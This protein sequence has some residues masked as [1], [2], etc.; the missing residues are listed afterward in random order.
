MSAGEI[1]AAGLLERADGVLVTKSDASFATFDFGE[2]EVDCVPLSFGDL[3]TAWWST[4]IRYIEMFVHVSGD[5]FPEGN[6]SL[7]PNGPSREERD[8]H[9]TRAVVEVTGRRGSIVRI[10]IDTP[11]G[12]SY[13]PIPAIEASRRVLAGDFRPGLQTRALVFGAEFAETI[14]G[15]KV[16]SNGEPPA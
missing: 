15:T 8:A 9:R 10:L 2:R 7:L 4:G 11:S 14:G 5:A 16:T 6:L 12:Y 13:T 1:I 3:V